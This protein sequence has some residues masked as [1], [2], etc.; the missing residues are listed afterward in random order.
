MARAIVV[1][2]VVSVRGGRADRRRWSLLKIGA[3]RQPRRLSL[4]NDD[5]ERLKPQEMSRPQDLPAGGFSS[6]LRAMRLALLEEDAADVPCGECTA[7]CMTSHFVH[8]RPEETEALAHIPRELQFPAPGL[9]KGN[10]L[11]GYNEN[12]HCPMLIDGACSI[13]E[14][15]PLT[16]RTYDCRVFAAAGIAAD[17]DLIR[18]RARRWKFSYPTPDDRAQHASVRAAA[19]FLRDRAGCFP[20][21]AV[22]RDPVLLAVLAVKVGD[23]F[24]RLGAAVGET[25]QS[26]SD[27]E[28]AKALV[29]ANKRFEA[30]CG[31]PQAF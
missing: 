8:V 27:Q 9:P 1:N 20:G 31:A 29:V 26:A 15:R 25:G 17:K 18:R 22:P 2:E 3:S 24:L 5:A 14:H 7:C 30:R 16:C 23:V 21:G 19:R 10:V 28:I 4:S 6:W 13:Y 11:L 12:G